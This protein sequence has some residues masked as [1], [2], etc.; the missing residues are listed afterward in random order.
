MNRTVSSDAEQIALIISV[1]ALSDFRAEES[2]ISGNTLVEMM[3]H[4]LETRH[5]CL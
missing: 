5:V 4:L 3:S 2:D 1:I